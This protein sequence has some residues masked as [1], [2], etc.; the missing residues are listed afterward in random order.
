M[1]YEYHF[2]ISRTDRIWLIF[3]VGLLLAWE[4][5]KPLLPAPEFE[6]LEIPGIVA[7][8]STIQNDEEQH[9][10]NR[11][12]KPRYKNKYGSS[13]TFQ[14]NPTYENNS[15]PIRIMEATWQEL[16]AVGF[17]PHVAS[18]IE[19]YLAAGG[20]IANQFQLMKIYGMD[21]AQWTKVSPYIIFPEQNEVLNDQTPGIH[22]RVY[23]SVTPLDLNIATID[24]LEKLPGIG[25]VLAE[26]IIKYR[27]SLGGYITVD[28][29]KECYGLPPET[30]EKIQSRL[31]LFTQ[32]KPISIN[33][34]DLKTFTHPY[35]DKK[36][37]KVLDAYRKQHGPY[38]GAEDLG[39]AY[40]AD[41]LWYKKVL[42]Y[43]VF[44]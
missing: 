27:N 11:E 26:R 21:T 40:P 28:Q 3:L 7:S 22:E 43:L 20:E 8:D 19:R 33:A 17:H 5:I 25:K 1:K 23:E 13:W 42:P 35:L 32:H 14:A 37:A 38:K 29:V 41:T 12:L 9:S 34:I 24:E 36:L 18:N 16:M 31:Q 4:L 44:E 39:Q 10:Y 15:S 30:F 6:L 2:T